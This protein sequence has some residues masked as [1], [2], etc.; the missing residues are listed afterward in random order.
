MRFGDTSASKRTTGVDL[1]D[2]PPVGLDCG[3]AAG[4]F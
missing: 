2:A 4:I 1:I 3:F